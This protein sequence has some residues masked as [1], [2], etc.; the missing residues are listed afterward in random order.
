MPSITQSVGV[1]EVEKRR[2]SN[3]R[4]RIGSESVSARL[5]PDRSASGAQIQTSSES[6]AAIRSSAAR[7]SAWIPSSLVK[8]MRI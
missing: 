2:S 5:A 8:R 4:T 1:P 6:L 7:P 3:C